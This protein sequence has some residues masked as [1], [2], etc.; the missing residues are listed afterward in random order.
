MITAK[1]HTWTLSLVGVDRS[2]MATAMRGTLWQDTWY[3]KSDP[4]DDHDPDAGLAVGLRIEDMGQLIAAIKALGHLRPDHG[5]E[6]VCH[7]EFDGIKS[8]SQL[9]VKDH[10]GW[11]GGCTIATD[12]NKICVDVRDMIATAR[13]A[14]SELDERITVLG[15]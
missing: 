13:R 3:E 6:L 14:L 7:A 2:E 5:M 10:A 12:R 11:C 1:N 4:V 15:G 8:C 9:A